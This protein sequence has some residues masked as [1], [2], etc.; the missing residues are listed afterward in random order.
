VKLKFA[1]GGT[2]E[3]GAPPGVAAWLEA[4][5]LQTENATAGP[6]EVVLVEPK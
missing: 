5:T 3:R 1:D 2:D 6:L 4:E